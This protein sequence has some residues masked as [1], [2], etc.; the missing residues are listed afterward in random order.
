MPAGAAVGWVRADPAVVKPFDVRA[1]EAGV[2]AVEGEQPAGCQDSCGLREDGREIIDVRRD[3]DRGNRRE[4]TVGERQGGPVTLHDPARPARGDAELAGRTVEADRDSP[5]GGDGVEVVAAAA[6][7]IEARAFAWTEQGS[8]VWRV[9]V[10][11]RLVP[12]VVPLRVPVITRLRARHLRLPLALATR[13]TL[14]S[15]RRPGHRG[16]F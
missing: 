9:L 10:G 3:I 15:R 2:R 8:R 1:V 11:V 6:A 14:A 7:E 4:G 13:S 5:G 16:S 12:G